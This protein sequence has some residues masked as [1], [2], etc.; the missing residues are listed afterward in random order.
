MSNAFGLIFFAL[1]C[2]VIVGVAAGI[3]WAVVRFTPKK[4]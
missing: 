2:F 3:T 4:D 1:Y